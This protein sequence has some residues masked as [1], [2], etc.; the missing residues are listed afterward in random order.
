MNGILAFAIAVLVH[1]AGHAV[2][3]RVLHLRWEIYVR[4]PFTLGIRA[5]PSRRVAA[6]GP[7]ASLLLALVALLVGW[8]ML[9]AASLAFFV[10]S[11]PPFKPCDG[12]WIFR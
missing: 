5:E 11:L 2:T 7:L 3:A 8:P 9:C 4:F 10:V 1:E 6:G 12:Y